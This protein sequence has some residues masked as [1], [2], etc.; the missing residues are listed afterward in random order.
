MN[1]LTIG[2]LCVGDRFTFIS[3]LD[4]TA[5]SIFHESGVLPLRRTTIYEITRQDR[6]LGTS[7]LRLNTGH[8]FRYNP[9]NNLEVLRVLNREVS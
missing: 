9:G 2:D 6:I 4:N 1:T 5:R 8:E 3:G 7:F